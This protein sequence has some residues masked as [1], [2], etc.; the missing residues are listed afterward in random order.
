MFLFIC[1]T[2]I[3]VHTCI[4]LLMPALGGESPGFVELL[5]RKVLE[6]RYMLYMYMY[7]Y[8]FFHFLRCLMFVVNF[9]QVKSSK[10][11]SSGKRSAEVHVLTCRIV[12]NQN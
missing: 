4:A 3:H 2:Y 8:T 12:S 7:M 5:Y 1:D 9:L 10:L 6:V 11:F